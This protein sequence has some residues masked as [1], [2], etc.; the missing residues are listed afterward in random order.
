MRE[1]RHSHDVHTPNRSPDAYVNIARWGRPRH[2]GRPTGATDTASIVMRVKPIVM[3]TA[4]VNI[5]IEL[6][7]D[8][9]AQSAMN[10]P[11]CAQGGFRVASVRTASGDKRK[12]QMIGDLIPGR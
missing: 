11:I 3:I 7:I 4:N 12:P 6:S 9:V 5:R 2:H 10:H 1:I 8:H